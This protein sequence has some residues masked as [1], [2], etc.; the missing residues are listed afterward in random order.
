MGI[1]GYVY[2]DAEGDCEAEE[3]QPQPVWCQCQERSFEG[4]KGEGQRTASCIYNMQYL[5]NWI[6]GYVTNICT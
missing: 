1:F 4:Q 2:R 3:W 6:Q 5:K